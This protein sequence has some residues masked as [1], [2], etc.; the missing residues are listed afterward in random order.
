MRD[1]EIKWPDGKRCAVMITFDVDGPSNWLYRDENIKNLPATYSIGEYGPLRGVPRILDL[2]EREQIKATFF[3]PGWTA[4]QYPDIFKAI[5]HAGHELGH[6]GYLHELFVNKT[7]E[8]QVE[9][10]DKSQKIFK[11]L[12]GSEARGFRTPSGDFSDFTPA[13]LEEK[14]FIYS[15]SMRGDDRPYH[16]IIDGRKSKLIEI[17]AKWELDDYAQFGFN[18]YPPTPRG[19]DRIAGYQS[20]LENWIYEFEGHYRYGLC[21]GLMLHPQVIGKPGRVQM[22]EKLIQYMKSF[23]DVWFA[24]G[25]EI[26]QW[27]QENY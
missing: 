17:P 8:E 25:E 9:I 21:F 18:Y 27:W 4:E 20:T 12:I 7:Y 23:P 19:Q 2:L 15:S 6:H 11:E 13:L 3:V 22:L 10:I 24:T 16:T 26:A 14:G 5:Y 1:K